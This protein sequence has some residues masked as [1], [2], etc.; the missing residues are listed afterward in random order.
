MKKIIGGGEQKKQHE[1]N[2]RKRQRRTNAMNGSARG[3]LTHITDGLENQ[4]MN[5]FC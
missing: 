4:S 2:K 5:P 1:I 3:N